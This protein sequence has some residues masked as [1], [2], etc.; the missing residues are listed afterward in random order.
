MPEVTGFEI[1]RHIRELNPNVKIVLCSAFEI[2]LSEFEKVMPHTHVD[3]FIR[4]PVNMAT[5]IH[6]VSEQ[7]ADSKIIPPEVTGHK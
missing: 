7:I 5:L 4:K 2:N 1:A 6:V 3:A